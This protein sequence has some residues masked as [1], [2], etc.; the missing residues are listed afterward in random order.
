MYVEN[1]QAH[2]LKTDKNEHKMLRIT[3]KI[4]SLLREMSG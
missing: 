4:N 2:P 3:T 1:D